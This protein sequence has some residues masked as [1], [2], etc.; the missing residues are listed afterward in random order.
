[1]ARLVDKSLVV[2]E[3]TAA[4]VRF[5]LLATLAEYGRQ[6]LVDSGDDGPVRQRHAR[7]VASLIDARRVP[8]GSWD[9]NWFETVKGSMDD[10]HLAMDWTL[11]DAD[12]NTALAIILA[13]TSFWNLGGQLDDCWPWVGAALSLDHRLRLPRVYALTMVAAMGAIG[14]IDQALL[15]A[16]EAVELG[17][18]IGNR[19]ALAFAEMVH[20]TLLHAF[21]E[22]RD[23]SLTLFEEAATLL[24]TESDDWAMALAALARSAAALTQSD[25]DIAQRE[26]RL[27]AD[28]F[29]RLG[30]LVSAAMALRQLADIAVSSGEYHEAI[31]ALLEALSGLQKMGADGMACPFTTRLGYVST[32]QGRFEDAD[33]WLAESRAWAERQQDVP[34]LALAHN[35]RGLSLRRR[36]KLDEAEQ[37]H[38]LALAIY[39][40]RRS[41]VGIATTLAALGYIAELRGDV[42]AAEHHHRASLDAACET[43]NRR[44]EALALEGLAGVASLKDDTL[45]VGRLLGAAAALR[46]SAVIPLVGAGTPLFEA[47]GGRLSPEER[48]DIN[49]AIGRVHDPTAM[50]AAFAEGQR[51]PEAV[52]AAARARVD[53]LSW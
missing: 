10:I 49:R 24:E 36:G 53:A 1:L 26:F 50:H 7:W 34:M 17:R 37:S 23:R 19:S 27:A 11:A 45:A 40:E 20:G 38:R 31:S 47:T 15:Y 8:F 32:L 3:Q 28:R 16:G 29:T 35:T 44:G 12:S 22:E 18:A 4:G 13:L 41:P 46:E 42:A 39:Y 5:R 33:G 25:L 30:N 43:P 48:I 21:M 14:H 51:D 52:V 2:A 9:R 6:R